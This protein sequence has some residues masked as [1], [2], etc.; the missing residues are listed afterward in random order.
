MESAVKVGDYGTAG[1]SV[2]E[3]AVKTAQDRPHHHLSNLLLTDYQQFIYIFSVTCHLTSQLLEEC[4]M[5]ISIIIRGRSFSYQMRD[6]WL[7]V[8]YGSVSRTIYWVDRAGRAL[9]QARTLS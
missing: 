1:G 4:W 8:T 9:P 6:S 2:M 7:G 3:S 5:V